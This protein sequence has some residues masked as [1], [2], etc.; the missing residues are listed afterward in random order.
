MQKDGQ[1]FTVNSKHIF[2]SLMLFASTERGCMICT[3]LY[4]AVCGCGDMCSSAQV[5]K[6]PDGFWET[7]ISQGRL[8]RFGKDNK[9]T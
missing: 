6:L 7:S 1:D 5:P 3:W 2:C 8:D 9:T 4:V